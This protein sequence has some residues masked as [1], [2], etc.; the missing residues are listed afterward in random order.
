[1]STKLVTY[2]EREKQFD[3]IRG[4]L[5]PMSRNAMTLA[6]PSK[7]S[8]LSFDMGIVFTINYFFSGKQHLINN[9]VSVLTS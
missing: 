3:K 2:Q 7:H 6:I 1:M 8:N 5:F 9:E 4:A